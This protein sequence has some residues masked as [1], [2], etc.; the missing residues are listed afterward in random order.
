MQRRVASRVNAIRACLNAEAFAT[1]P[2]LATPPLDRGM[3]E[4]LEECLARLQLVWRRLGAVRIGDGRQRLVAE[5]EMVERACAA[6][7][8]LLEAAEGPSSCGAPMSGRW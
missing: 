2:R 8:A 3:H 6:A 1:D 5:F 4:R 7:D